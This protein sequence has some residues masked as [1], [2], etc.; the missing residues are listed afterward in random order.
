MLLNGGEL[1]GV[2][3]LEPTTAEMIMTDQLPELAKY[4]EKVGY[5]LA[6]SVD[7][8][9]GV[10]GWAGAA[11]TKFWIDPANEMIIMTF[12]Q[13]MPSDYSYANEFYETVR[14]GLINN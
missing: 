7:L 1:N 13:L 8:E 3:I 12:A 5:G 6:G 14:N 10:Y 2:R 4:Q 11:S 9:R